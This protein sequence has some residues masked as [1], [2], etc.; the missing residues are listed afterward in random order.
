MHSDSRL[1]Y[2]YV[3]AAATLWGTLGVLAKW[4]YA[5]Q[6]S[7]LSVVWVRAV[8]AFIG[9]LVLL[10]IWRPQLLKVS[11][12][13]LPFLAGYGLIS[14]AAFTL[15]YFETIAA[16]TVGAAAVLLYSAPVFVTLLAF[17]LFGE[18]LGR[19]KLLALGI[20]TVGLV[21]VVGGYDPA[22]LRV[23]P[24][25]IATGLGSG[26][27][28]GLYSIFGK[29][30]LSKYS[31]WTVVLYTLGFGGFFLSLPRGPAPGIALQQPILAWALLASVAAI[32]IIAF[33]SYT[34]GLS[35]I[36]AGR[37]SIVCTLE[38]VVA[39]ALGQ[40][41]FG[42]VMGLAQVLGAGLVLLGAA[43]TQLNGRTGSLPGAVA[44]AAGVA[45]LA[46]DESAGP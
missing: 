35:R 25:A 45:S 28:Y 21:L 4:L 6:L 27:T 9:L 2:A 31:S 40:L 13:D 17:L 30:A 43:A 36:E 18:P 1:Y 10:A 11:P 14:V 20:A 26:L 24:V 19:G 39:S 32:T 41:A 33:G 29:V 5:Y 23:T 42:E 15:L 44:S 38:P 7:P 8:G 34:L 46:E 37:A 22:R 3:V 16:S 12:G